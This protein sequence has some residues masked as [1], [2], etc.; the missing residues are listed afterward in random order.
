[1]EVWTRCRG[2]FEKGTYIK[3]QFTLLAQIPTWN[4]IFHVQVK[5]LKGR[6][7]SG[8]PIPRQLYS[9]LG[10]CTNCNIERHSR[11]ILK[12]GG[13]SLLRLEN[14][15]GTIFVEERRSYVIGNIFHF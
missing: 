10:D 12:V 3:K 6:G 4:E 13:M 2:A 5:V 9:P 15:H 7:A 14:V 1:M 8:T 11:W